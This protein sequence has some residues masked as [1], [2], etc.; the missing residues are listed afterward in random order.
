MSRAQSLPRLSAGAC[1]VL[2]R[3]HGDALAGTAMVVRRLLLVEQPGPW[4]WDPVVES[5]L[6]P[7][8]GLA[9][10]RRCRDAGVR[11]LLL[12]RPG[13]HAS[14]PPG[15]G[16]ER[17]WFAV[18]TRPGRTSVRSGRFRRDE[19][20]LALP[21]DGRTGDP[22]D[23]SLVLVCTN[24]RHDTCC[25]TRGR[26][27]V[28]ALAALHPGEV[29]ECSHVGGDRF[30]ANVVVLPEGL[31]YGGLDPASAVDVLAAHE[32]GLAS[33]RW[34]RGRCSLPPAAQ[35]AQV[36]AMRALDRVRLDDLP[37]LEVTSSRDGGW[38]VLLGGEQ[39]V[40]VLVRPSTTAPRRLTCRATTDVAPG[41]FALVGIE[42]VA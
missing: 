35:A 20:L 33:P 6:D 22:H 15:V 2:A 8:H 11:L 28:A 40:V 31:Y 42:T 5:R 3:E 25:A 27:V 30:A 13:R 1:S 39:P 29:W 7:T 26:P 21:L 38:R 9:L 10:A 17:A 12:R 16:Q 18:D 32:R 23:R 41:S 34:L 19:E 36:H 4:G 14:A 37:V 24:G